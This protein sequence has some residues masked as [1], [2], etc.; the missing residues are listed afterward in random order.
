MRGRPVTLSKPRPDTSRRRTLIVACSLGVWMFV[1][2]VRLIQLQTSQHEWLRTRALTQ[3]QDAIET[4]PFRG[5]VLDR[6]GSELAR[7]IDTESFFAVPGEI[8]NVREFA[9]RLASAAGLEAEAL[10]NRLKD[11]QSANRKF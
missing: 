11:A 7:S 4:S 3:Q 2:G 1:I 8:K 10:E 9:V 6:N 5:L